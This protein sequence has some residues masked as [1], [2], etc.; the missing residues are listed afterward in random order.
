MKT[1][2]LALI[3]A[4]LFAAGA[5][6][7]AMPA[8]ADG[9]LIAMLGGGERVQGNGHVVSQARQPGAFHGIELTV[10]AHVKCAS[11]ATTR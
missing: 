6:A 2:T 3:A 4:T 7:T 1:K 9:G 5:L 10:P 11:A 8:S